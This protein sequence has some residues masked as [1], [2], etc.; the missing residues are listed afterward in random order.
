MT[1]KT[2][3]RLGRA[4]ASGISLAL[5]LLGAA[6]AWGH[7]VFPTKVYPSDS[8]QR[9]VLDVAHERGPDD[10]NVAVDVAMPA[11]WNATACE[12]AAP[13]QC[14]IDA[15]NPKV[16][17]FSKD[18]AAGPTA[19]D[20]TFVFTAR[21]GPPGNHSFPTNQTYNTG[22]RIAWAGPVGSNEPAPVLKTEAGAPSPSTTSPETPAQGL[23]S[24]GSTAPV[25]PGG[26]GATSPGAG[27]DSAGDAAANASQKPASTGA[28]ITRNVGVALALIGLGSLLWASSRRRQRSVPSPSRPRR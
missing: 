14:R 10:F 27:F 8:D 1:A 15:G 19:N 26:P 21:T 4:A 13:W 23:T 12:A 3:R 28:M 7:A 20:E 6:P 22:E 2:T 17:R 9:I 18:A 11:G 24:D 16:V 5:L 25:T